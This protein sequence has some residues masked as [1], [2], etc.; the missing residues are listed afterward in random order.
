MILTQREI[1]T[2]G[3]KNGDLLLNRVNSIELLGKSAYI[4]NLNEP[5][6]FESKNIRIRFSN[7]SIPKF[8]NYLF[9]TSILKD[10]ILLKF[11]KVTGQASINQD[12]L[13]TLI[14]PFPP[15][16]EQQLIVQKLEEFMQLI[17]NLEENLKQGEL[18]TVKLLQQVLKE[19]LNN[20]IEEE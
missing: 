18:Q 7:N 3:L 4:D 11:K 16:S 9:Q 20:R 6:V 1:E 17:L 14:I 13:S 15:L 5:T 10:Q 12:Q 19:V 8:I 2:Y